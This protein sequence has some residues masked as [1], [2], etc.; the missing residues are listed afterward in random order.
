MRNRSTPA[1]KGIR[2]ERLPS[3]ASPRL[4]ARRAAGAF[5][6]TGVASRTL[7][8]SCR[9]NSNARP[10]TGSSAMTSMAR[11]AGSRVTARS[12]SA[13]ARTASVSS[14]SAPASETRSII[15]AGSG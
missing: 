14:V 10:A 2:Q 3:P 9:E 7:S 6:P 11:V 1:G 12:T 8:D 15:P 4:P 5:R 13:A